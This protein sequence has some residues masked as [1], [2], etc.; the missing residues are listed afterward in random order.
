[1]IA[2]VAREEIGRLVFTLA[3]LRSAGPPV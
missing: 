1:M 3:D 2:A